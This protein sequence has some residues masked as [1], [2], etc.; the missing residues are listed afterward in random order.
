MSSLV[1]I[2][3]LESTISKNL[4][5]FPVWSSIK[6]AYDFKSLATG[7]ISLLRSFSSIPLLFFL[8]FSFHSFSFFLTYLLSFFLTR[9][10]SKTFEHLLQ[11]YICPLFR[12]SI[13]SPP[14][15]DESYPQILLLL[16]IW[17]KYALLEHFCLSISSRSISV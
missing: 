12:E 11:N 4:S 7:S 9:V 8:A 10:R 5:S 1:V 13:P 14:Y 15:P 3:L 6:T 17:F 16:Q 2:D